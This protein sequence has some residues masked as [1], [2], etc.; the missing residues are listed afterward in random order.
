[1]AEK[2]QIEE[3]YDSFEANQ[4]KLGISVRHRIIHNNLCKIGLKNNS[5]VLEIGCGIGTVSQLIIRSIPHGKF[6]G[7]DISPK[8]IETARKKNAESNVTFQVTD[9]SDFNSDIKFDFIVFPDVLEHIP[10]EQHSN[11]FEKVAK[12]CSPDAKILINIPEPN[13]LN[14]TRKNRPEVLQIIDQSLSMQDLLNNTYP[15]GFQVQSIHP[16]AIHTNVANY[17]SIVL[18]KNGEVKNIELKGKF[19]QLIQNLRVRFLK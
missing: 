19:G 4:K 8:S 9:M 3:F 7:C 5:N 13:C 2:V 10:V 12:V 15:H 11:M 18:I 16:Y 17:L 1:M 14:W 6:H